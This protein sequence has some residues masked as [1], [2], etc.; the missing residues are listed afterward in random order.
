MKNCEHKWFWQ[1]VFPSKGLVVHPVSGKVIRYH[2]QPS[3]T[4][5]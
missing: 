5:D 3:T 4:D 2:I 1:W